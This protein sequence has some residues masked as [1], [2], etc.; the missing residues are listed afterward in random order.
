M[1]ALAAVSTRALAC[2]ASFAAWAALWRRLGSSRGSPSVS[3]T[4]RALRAATNPTIPTPLPSSSTSLSR[5]RSGSPRVQSQRES[6]TPLS[7]SRQP[8]QKRSSRNW[9]ICTD[10]LAVRLT[11]LSSKFAEESA[12]S[13]SAVRA[14]TWML[15]RRC[16]T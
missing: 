10:S 9:R 5:K 12:S 7:H 11:V 14:P 3:R 8:E 2:A 4:R 6:A 16:T 1:G 15:S 13:C